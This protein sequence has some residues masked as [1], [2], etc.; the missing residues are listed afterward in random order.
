MQNKDNL[1]GTANFARSFPIE[2]F[3]IDQIL[4]FSFGSFSLGKTNL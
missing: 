4:I 1:P 2:S 3:T